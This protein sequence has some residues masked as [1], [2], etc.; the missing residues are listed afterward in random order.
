MRAMSDAADH[1]QS[2]FF[3]IPRFRLLDEKKKKIKEAQVGFLF[4]DQDGVRQDGIRIEK[5]LPVR[6]KSC[7]SGAMSRKRSQAEDEPTTRV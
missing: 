4:F 5:I 2:L 6:A 7:I 3:F 1:T